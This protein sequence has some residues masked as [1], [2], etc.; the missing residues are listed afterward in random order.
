MRLGPWTM[1]LSV[2]RLNM[3]RTRTAR[4][5]WPKASRPPSTNGGTHI[6]RARQI[7]IPRVSAGGLSLDAADLRRLPLAPPPLLDGVLASSDWSA[8][9]LPMFDVR[10]QAVQTEKLI[11]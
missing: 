1:R 3:A 9:V 5:S 6:A 4:V 2:Q 10:G 8:M 7:S 11:S